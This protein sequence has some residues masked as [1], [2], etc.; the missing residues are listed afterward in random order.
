HALVE[1]ILATGPVDDVDLIVLP[2]L[3]YLAELITRHGNSHIRFGAQ[4]LDIHQQGA[5]TGEV[6]GNMLRDIGAT[7]VLAGHSERRELHAEGNEL[8]AEKFR[9]AR[10]SGLTP[11]LCIGETR[12]Q[13]ESGSTFDVLRAQLAPVLSLGA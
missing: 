7:Y 13:R 2:P 1:G 11:I 10:G 3:P 8:V 12:A 5:F 6:A 9:F 4:N